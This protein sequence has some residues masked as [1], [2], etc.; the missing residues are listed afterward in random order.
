MSAVA[1]ATIGSSI[2]GGIVS[3]NAASKAAKA[4]TQ[5]AEIAAAEQRAAR[6]ELRRLLA[7]YQSAG[8]PALQEQMN[9]L[10]IAPQQT[11][12]AAFAQS[13]PEL[14]AA[15]NAQGGGGQ[16]IN[17]MGQQITIPGGP[18]MPLEQF[19]Q[20]WHQSKGGD[21]SRFQTGGAQGQQQAINQFEQSP[22]FQSLAR[23]GEEAILQNA[24]ATGGLRGGNVQGALAQF[25]PAL[26]N[27]QLQQQFQNLAGITKIGQNSAAGIGESSQLAATNIGNAAITAGQAQAGGYLGQGSAI[28]N[29]LGQISGFAASGGFG[30]MGGGIPL[31][32]AAQSQQIALNSLSSVPIARVSGF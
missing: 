24:S 32:T 2:I 9:L 27:Q 12:W 13:N 28:N 25:R 15:Y 1:A 30:G 23:Q 14:M 26:L 3:S 5:S 6:E 18:K 21:L 20:Q 31:P 8:I 22:M 17:V 29:A 19:A 4:Q 16:T 10:G 7:P 11:N